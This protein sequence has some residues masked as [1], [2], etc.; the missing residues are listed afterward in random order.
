MMQHPTR[1]VMPYTFNINIF[2]T[3]E[4]V[5]HLKQSREQNAPEVKDPGTSSLTS[6]QSIVHWMSFC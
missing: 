4:V 1:I 3:G 6:P 2:K 5:L